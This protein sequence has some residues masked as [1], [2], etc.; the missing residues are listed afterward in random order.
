MIT[1]RHCIARS[2]KPIP[3]VSRKKRMAD[4]EWKRVTNQ[5]RMQV[6]GRCEIGIHGICLGRGSQGH[7]RKLRS[8]G[9]GNTLCNCLWVCG[10]CHSAI[11]DSPAL[12]REHG[13][14]ISGKA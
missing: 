1:R 13:W 7:H 6:F 8:A 11:H 5:R 12:A 10:P 4:A 2:R 14:I 3:R 9:G